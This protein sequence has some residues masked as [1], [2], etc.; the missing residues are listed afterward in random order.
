VLTDPGM[1]TDWARAV[2]DWVAANGRNPTDIFHHSRT[3]RSLVRRRVIGERFGG[4]DDRRRRRLLDGTAGGDKDG[5]GA[6]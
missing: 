5:R 6:T 4:A 1:T 2:G 3:R